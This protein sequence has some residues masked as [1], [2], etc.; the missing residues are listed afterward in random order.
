MTYHR[1]ILTTAAALALGAGAAAADCAEELAQL[2]GGG[3]AKDGSLAPL[4]GV[5]AE[6]PQAGGDA[7]TGE[8]SAEGIV[9]DGTMEPLGAAENLAAL[10]QDVVAQQEGGATA[11]EQA[12][13]AP[14][15]GGD[16]DAAI[17]RA[18]QALDA[19]DEAGCVSAI[20]E[21]EGT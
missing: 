21:A 19:G 18:Q 8:S 7:V 17:A 20:E 16:R 5:A 1:L 14:A 13:G 2:T 6:T 12:A 15:A 9:K 10:E 4:E 11:A 3:I